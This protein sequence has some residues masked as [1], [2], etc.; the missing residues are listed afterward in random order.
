MHFLKS[1]KGS[2][3]YAV[4]IPSLEIWLSLIFVVESFLSFLEK[5][6]VK[7]FRDMESEITLFFNLIHRVN[8]LIFKKILWAV[9]LN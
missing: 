8:K 9:H 5:R 6:I 1:S 4:F 3:L 7:A 2:V